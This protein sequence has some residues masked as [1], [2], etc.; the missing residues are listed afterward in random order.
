MMR[1]GVRTG[2]DIALSTVDRVRRVLESSRIPMSRNQVLDRLAASGHATTRQRL[3][4][5]LAFFFDL[6]LAIEGSKGVQWTH[7]DSESLRRAVATGRR[8]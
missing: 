4:R 3:N 8:L 5:A 1:R 2:P 7:T 6:G